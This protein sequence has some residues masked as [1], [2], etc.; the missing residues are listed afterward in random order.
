M[1]RLSAYRNNDVLCTIDL[2]RHSAT[3][4]YYRLGMETAKGLKIIFRLIGIM[5]LDQVF[6]KEENIT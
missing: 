1:Q 5:E 3:F 4:L 6:M 2:V